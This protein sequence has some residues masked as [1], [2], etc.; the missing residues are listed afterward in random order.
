MSLI[1][2][3]W[4]ED[5]P[6]SRLNRYEEN[7]TIEKEKDSFKEKDLKRMLLDLVSITTEKEIS[8]VKGLKKWLDEQNKQ[9]RK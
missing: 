9:K 6:D 4:S 8:L 7:R 2:S 5:I 1:G 3:S